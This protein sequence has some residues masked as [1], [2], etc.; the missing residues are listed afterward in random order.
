M[1]RI[2]A[3]Q[4]GRVKVKQFQAAGAKGQL[5]R[6]WQLFFTRKWSDWLPVYCWLVEHPTGPFLVDAGEIARVHEPGYLPDSVVFRA[7]VQ[8]E[9]N[10]EDEVDRQLEKLGYAPGQIKGIFLT[11]LH[12]DHVDGIYH[13][14]DAKIFVSRAACDMAF[15]PNAQGGGYLRQNFPDWFQPQ[16]FEFGD[17][18]EGAFP[19]SKKLLADGSLLAVPLPGHADGHT[20]YIVKADGRRYVFSGDA[21]F[22]RQTLRDG[23]PFVVLDNAEAQESVGRLKAYAQSPD[24]VVLCSHD[25]HVPE[26]LGR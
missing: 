23:I 18:P 12:T 6:L 24:V 15:G 26:I 8:Y 14:P 20:G 21:T 5:S 2:H 1:I 19:A 9:V 4:T 3:I 16:A 10:R 7:A 17:G 25:P 22:D 13:F 11:H